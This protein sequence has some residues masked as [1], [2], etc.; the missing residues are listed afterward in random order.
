M[1]KQQEELTDIQYITALLE[2][3][4][5]RT[6]KI[7]VLESNFSDMIFYSLLISVFGIG[8]VL[9]ANRFIP[10]NF[11][12]FSNVQPY[13]SIIIFIATLILLII[14]KTV[15]TPAKKSKKMRK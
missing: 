13:I 10:E 5:E 11:L 3:V 2:K 7:Q 12:N 6:N 15:M 9:L 8:L 14:T 1:D 4:F